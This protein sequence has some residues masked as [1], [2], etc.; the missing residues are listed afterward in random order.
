MVNLNNLNNVV[1]YLSTMGIH[2][3]IISPEDVSIAI[4]Y[5]CIFRILAQGGQCYKVTKWQNTM[6]LFITNVIIHNLT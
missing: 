3:N 4:N 2:H 5:H 6:E 1:I